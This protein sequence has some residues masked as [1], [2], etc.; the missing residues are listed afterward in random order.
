MKRYL[1]AIFFAVV[2]A[3]S[4]ASAQ[5]LSPIVNFGKPR[6][7]YQ[8]PGDVFGSAYAWYSCAR[9]YNAAYAVGGTN[10][11]CD[12]VDVSTG[13]ITCT[14]HIKSN[15]LVNPSECDGVGQ[16]CQTSCKITQIYDQ[17][18]NS[19][20]LN[21]VTGTLLLNISSGNLNSLPTI[22]CGTGATDRIVTTG[23]YTV[24][25]PVTMSGVYIR[26]TGTASGGVI[27]NASTSAIYMGPLNTANEGFVATGGTAVSFSATDN[28]WHGLQG[29]FNGG[30]SASA[31]NIDGSDNSAS[32]VS[33]TP[34]SANAIGVCRAGGSQ[35]EGNIAEAGFWAATSTATQRNNL[36]ANQNGANG[37]NGNL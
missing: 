18:G 1:A 32:L 17:S 28:A 11:A 7:T 20:P 12:V 6:A 14:Y 31:Y 22:N 8:G 10:P 9:G 23:T 29:L 24:S 3:W 15:G 25:Q 34:L 35:V 26:T 19:R 4:F 5:M 30:S 21:S 37:Y 36:F 27:G 13:L 16:S 33:N 2:C